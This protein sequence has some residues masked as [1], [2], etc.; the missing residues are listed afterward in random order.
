MDD[1]SNKFIDEIGDVKIVFTI[2][3][4]WYGLS[5]KISAPIREICLQ[6]N[7]PF[8][9]FSNDPKYVHNSNYFKDGSHLNAKGADEFTR[10]LI[11]ALKL[12]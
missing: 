11:K 4:T 7:I 6:K 10:D 2:S 5:Q 1:N 9:D 12:K 8:L 3:P